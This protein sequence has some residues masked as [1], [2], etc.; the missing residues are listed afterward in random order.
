MFQ[1]F[2]RGTIYAGPGGVFTRVVPRSGSVF[3]TPASILTWGS[4]P[5]PLPDGDRI[6][7]S[8]TTN[9][10]GNPN[11][12]TRL[13]LRAGPGITWW[14][15]ISVASQGGPDMLQASTQDGFTSATVSIPA[16]MLDPA[17]M[18]LHFGKAKFLGVHT[19]VYWLDRADQLIGSDVT[20]TWLAD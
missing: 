18:M 19:G 3:A 14:K 7:V 9:A 12:P 15:A 4:F 17:G 1:D 8:F 6:A 5:G 16:S 10:T 2:S 11:G 20:F 13:T